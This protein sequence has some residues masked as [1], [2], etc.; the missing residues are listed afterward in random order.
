MGRVTSA[1]GARPVGGTMAAFVQII[2]MTTKKIDEVRALV[3][4]MQEER[5]AA[6]DPLPATMSVFTADRDRPNTYLAI[7]EFPSYDV[8]MAN[9]SHPATQQYS[10]NLA[11][12][13]EAPPLFR[14][15]DVVETMI[16]LVPQG[17][18]AK[19]PTPA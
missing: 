17:S 6:G 12:L 13:C 11:A 7:V 3:D 16:A 9:S 5:K 1:V 8:A 2:E 4:R 18:S 14:N 19:K 10:A 15:L